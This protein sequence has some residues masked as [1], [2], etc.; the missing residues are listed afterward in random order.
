M[1]FDQPFLRYALLAG[2]PIAASA[3]L[4]GYFL[5][6]RAQVFSADALGHV[7]Y[8]GALAALAFGIDP[9]IGL[10]GATA[11]IGILLGL[12]D[13]RDRPDDVAIGS[14]F[15]WVL[16]LGVFFLTIY[17][18]TRSGGNGTASANYLFGSIY[19]LSLPQ[20]ILAAAIAGGAALSTVAIARP[21]LYASIDPTVAAARG[22]PVSLLGVAIIMLT[23]LVTAEA[24]QAVGALLSL[25]LIAAP[26]GAAARLV[27]RPYRALAASAAIAVGSLW[28]GLVL[29]YAVPTL[30]P[31]FSVIAVATALFAA[32]RLGRPRPRA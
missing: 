19:G 3:G 4:I 11:G 14:L 12:L 29:S 21:L 16:G 9:R 24:T 8:T 25:G 28:A 32:T 27:H 13:G 30:P 7:A 22:L 18:T 23:G 5:L 15:A 17:T 2:T 31:S 26:A 1:I 10:L 20:A 6:L